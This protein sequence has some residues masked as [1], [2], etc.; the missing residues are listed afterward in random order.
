MIS[1]LS[2]ISDQEK[3]IETYYDATYSM[4]ELLRTEFALFDQNAL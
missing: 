4:N 3:S 1:V 2:T